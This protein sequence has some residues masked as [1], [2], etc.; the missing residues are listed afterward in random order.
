MPM[1][2]QYNSDA[3]SNNNL[4]DTSGGFSLMHAL[5]G[6]ASVVSASSHSDV[7]ST[8]LLREGLSI[9]GPS[10]TKATSTSTTTP[11]SIS[12]HNSTA[13]SDHRSHPHVGGMMSH[14]A[15][16][17]AA[18]PIRSTKSFTSSSNY[19]N[20]QQKLQQQRRSVNYRNAP[21]KFSP[22]NPKRTAMAETH[23]IGSASGGGVSRWLASAS[24]M[25]SDDRLSSS[26][27][28]M[29]NGSEGDPGHNLE[30]TSFEDCYSSA[31]SGYH[32]A[33]TL[34]EG[35]ERGD[36][37]SGSGNSNAGVNAN[38]NTNANTNAATTPSPR[39]GGHN[40][41]SF[42]PSSSSPKRINQK[43]S[44]S[45]KS[46][47]MR[48]HL[49]GVAQA[50][51]PSPRREMTTILSSNSSGSSVGSFEKKMLSH[52]TI[53]G[54]KQN[55]FT[56]LSPP[57]LLDDASPSSAA[58]TTTTTAPPNTPP[59]G[60]VPAPY[61]IEPAPS[62]G[63]PAP[64]SAAKR[65]PPSTTTSAAT[66]RSAF[67]MT[68]ALKAR[69]AARAASPSP[70]TT[71]PSK[72]QTRSSASPLRHSSPISTSRMKHTLQKWSRAGVRAGAG[73]HAPTSSEGSGNYSDAVSQVL[74][75]DTAG[76]EVEVRDGKEAKP[77]KSGGA[78]SS[79][80]KSQEGIEVVS[81]PGTPGSKGMG[82]GNFK[83]GVK[84]K[85][86]RNR[87]PSP[88]RHF[89]GVGGV[90]SVD[91]YDDAATE[92]ANN[93]TEKSGKS[94]LHMDKN[95]T[96]STPS[97]FG[98]RQMSPGRMKRNFKNRLSKS[99]VPASPRQ[100][101]GSQ[102]QQHNASRQVGEWPRTRHQQYQPQHQHTPSPEKRQLPLYPTSDKESAEDDEGIDMVSASLAH[103]TMSFDVDE[104][105]HTHLQHPLSQCISASPSFTSDMVESAP[106]SMVPPSPIQ[107]S[108]LET[109]E[110]YFISTTS[111]NIFE[112][113]EFLRAMGGKAS[114][115]SL[116]TNYI[117][118]GDE[119]CQKKD[120]DVKER[121]ERAVEVYYA[122]LGKILTRVR[123]WSMEQRG[124]RQNS[125]ELLDENG[126]YIPFKP[127]PEVSQLLYKDFVE[128]AHSPET[129]VLLLAMS[130]I[131]LRAG[132]AHFRRK[133]WKEACRDY[134][135]A[136]SYRSLRHEAK[137]ITSEEKKEH[138]NIYFEDAKL[139]GRISNNIASAQSKQKMYEEARSEY[140]KALQI[141]QGTLEALHKS[142]TNKKGEVDDSNL[143][144]DIA[145]TFH[146]IG[147]LRMN[148]GEPK[149]AEK[150]YKQSLSLRVKK[151]GLDDLG[152]SSTLRALGDLYH[153]LKQYDDAFRSYKESL[154]I[155]KSHSGKSDLRTAEHYYNIGLVFYS[156]GPFVKARTS[157]AECLRIR[158]LHCSRKE[159]LPVAAAL[160]LLGLIASSSG[161][162][163]EA[164]SLLEE[165]LS[166]RQ[167]LLESTDYLLLSN[168][169]L[170]LGIVYHKRNDLQSAMDCF[171]LALVGR[172]QCLGKDHL[173][174]SEVLQAIGGV[175]TTAQDYQKAFKT[176]EEALCIRKSASPNG[177]SL[178]VAETL[179]ELSLV[180]FKSGDAEKAI[181]LSEEAL[182][183]LKS[184]VG[185]DHL[186]V[187]KVLKNT[188]D[189]YQDMEAYDDA[190]E[191]YSESLRVMTAWHGRE[192]VF[193]SEVLNE[194]GVTRFKNGEYKIAKQSFT[195]ALRLMRLT[196][197]DANKS[198]VFPT[199]NHL[200]HALYKNNE[201]ELAAETY[202]DSFNIQAS[203][204]TG[205][206]NDGMKEFSAKLNVIK[207]RIAIMEQNE[208]D[209]VELS[210]SL[211]GIASILRYL[212]L[213]IQEQ[214]DFEA[215]LSVNKLS[216]SV[217][218]CQ[219]FKEYSSMALMAETIAMFEY[220]RNNLASAM[221]YFNQAL[222]AKKSY[223]GESTIDVARTVNNLAN[224]HFSLG[225][226]DDAMVLYQEAFKIKR[227]CLGDDSDEVA[228]TLNNIAHVMVNAGK[229]Q[230]A[231]GA[232]HN[233]LRIRQDRYGKSHFSVATTLAS[234]GDV[235]IKLGK[236]EI[237]M[238]Y[239]EQCIRIQ[240]LH[241]DHCDERVLENLGSIY[242]KLGEWH[243]AESTFEEIIALKRAAH[244]N[245]CLE[246]AKTLD[247]LAV[248]YIEQNRH[249]ESIEHLREALRIRK[250]CLDDDDDEILASLNKLAFVYKSLG[251]TEQMMEMREEFE[252][253][254]ER[255]RKGSC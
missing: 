164:L 188:G 194:I 21:K 217:R 178:E 240:K 120:D 128:I 15:A 167:A 124:Q 214:G 78:K 66:A 61:A 203:I 141:K 13:S 161:N 87:S 27:G 142:N 11:K 20:Q 247:L 94:N 231:L 112:S 90:G 133:Q 10:P 9:T 199:L 169:Q 150:A 186:L 109:Q 221:D 234:M 176:L 71:S 104:A 113:R 147:L 187:G 205:D 19:Y 107:E 84:A 246:V 8:A 54:S 179:D 135:S 143:V 25:D 243:K 202:L 102:Q 154:R 228:N 110:G 162:Y 250:A 248:S 45:L 33:F 249:V 117:W 254:Q 239:F 149:K 100:N 215:A 173:L 74:R 119:L 192:H 2:T 244:G 168:V 235:Y 177:S 222:D 212:G 209:V 86:F 31:T 153:H 171:S 218:L 157:V 43:V 138:N 83:G 253:H 172:S 56:T 151:F 47:P 144:S 53:N 63:M 99:A 88:I 175:Y 46:S 136:Q 89:G 125:S 191:A 97:F 111:F 208:E 59:H 40:L 183:V 62:F 122:G 37:A 36:N 3:K 28:G 189:Y 12:S 16:V 121:L 29:G 103:T 77:T 232:Y 81:S 137:D 106:E 165:S 195:E 134:V 196:H 92:A 159:R 255:R 207:N 65:K 23:G 70:A 17:T 115:A 219:P 6:G 245:E 201:L 184:A 251:M 116:A 129:N 216:L 225:N 238:T 210:E 49:P 220:K 69:A 160:Y 180:L 41:R 5:K 44:S 233:V 241:Q 145:S 155:W 223:Q 32:D 197:N 126:N 39:S 22:K 52:G 227:H 80:S 105:P 79:G 182:E 237:A 114:E 131:L 73:R 252:A 130:S 68:T 1:T 58:T 226:L 64:P 50:T 48:N 190:M 118:T 140:T 230:E 35:V 139:N 170:A 34:L 236:L 38:A 82:F 181:E 96:A 127:A 24:S 101:P 26:R 7:D 18:V 85:S 224:I 75:E 148:C 229:E 158:R 76:Q 204:V 146:N 198:A 156:K 30:T 108:E 152:I 60:A 57:T 166:L 206:V 123:D 98:I 55:H 174:V 14:N 42:F 163:D 185:F 67:P 211:G 51:T 4:G 242:G 91:N 93:N 213:V 132:N 200:G 95:S 72:R 193:L